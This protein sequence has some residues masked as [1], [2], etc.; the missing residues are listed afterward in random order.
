M[1]HRARER[2]L[3]AQKAIQILYQTLQLLHPLSRVL[4][5]PDPARRQ[6]R[7]Q[8]VPRRRQALL[9]RTPARATNG[10]AASWR[11]GALRWYRR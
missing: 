6:L 8:P 4:V 10:P 1:V 9:L 11:V 5:R 3:S 2:N 7:S